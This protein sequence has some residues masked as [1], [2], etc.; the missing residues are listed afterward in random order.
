M[1]TGPHSGGQDGGSVPITLV[2]SARKKNREEEEEAE[3]IEAFVPGSIVLAV[4]T[5]CCENQKLVTSVLGIDM[6]KLSAE[7]IEQAAQYTN[8]VRDRELDLR[9]L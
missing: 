2:A 1:I 6:V 9:G 3:V 4:R 8:P 7:L 5:F